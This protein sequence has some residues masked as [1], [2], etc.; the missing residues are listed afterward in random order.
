[1]K[2]TIYTL[3]IFLVSIQ[4][5]G[6]LGETQIT[7]EEGIEVFQKEKYYLLKKNVEIVSD[8]FNL[9][10]DVVKAYF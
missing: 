4:A 1:M 2:K 6:E 7:A 3:I 10:A 9:N 8:N 5:K